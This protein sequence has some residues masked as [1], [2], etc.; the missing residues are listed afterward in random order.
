MNRILLVGIALGVLTGCTRMATPCDS[1]YMRGKMK[2]AFVEAV[3]Y[4][5]WK[6]R[7]DLFAAGLVSNVRFD[8]IETDSKGG[9][10]NAAVCRAT[11]RFDVAGTTVEDDFGYLVVS[12]SGEDL[13]RK[14]SRWPMERLDK[15][16][17]KSP[18][19]EFRKKEREIFH[20]RFEL[21]PDERAALGDSHTQ[22]VQ[23]AEAELEAMRERIT[24]GSVAPRTSSTQ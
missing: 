21:S 20:L 12:Q 14:T 23:S 19:G 7:I 24:K 22:K 17:M 4:G 13:F 6:S 1:Q 18:M 2:E 9:N 8:N 10:G 3:N 15:L 16:L 5:Y 11:I